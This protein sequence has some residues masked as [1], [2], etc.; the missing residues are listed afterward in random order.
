MFKLTTMPGVLLLL[1]IE[2]G[3]VEWRSGPS[4]SIHLQCSELESYQQ[5]QWFTWPILPLYLRD[6]EAFPDCSSQCQSGFLTDKTD[7]TLARTNPPMCLSLL[8]VVWRNA[9]VTRASYVSH[10]KN[11]SRHTLFYWYMSKVILWINAQ[12]KFDFW[13]WSSE[14]AKSVKAF[15]CF[16]QPLTTSLICIPVRNTFSFSCVESVNKV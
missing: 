8:S 13:L 7:D 6:T 16:R 9:I 3:R 12:V 2:H 5:L 4:G 14:A 15:I 1:S 11:S 10:Y